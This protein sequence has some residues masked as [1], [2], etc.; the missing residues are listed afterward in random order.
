MR[1][2][3]EPPLNIP[4]IAIKEPEV[5]KPPTTYIISPT[6]GMGQTSRTITDKSSMKESSFVFERAPVKKKPKLKLPEKYEKLLDSII[7]DQVET[8]DFT[9]AELGDQVM[10]QIAE[11]IRGKKIKTLK[12]IR[13]KLTDEALDKMLPHFGGIITLNLSQ[14]LLTDRFIDH[15]LNHLPRLPLLKS[16]ILSQNKIKER[17]VK[18]RLEEIK[19]YEI[20][21]SL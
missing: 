8:A 12:L 17:S 6:N 5:L 20:V 2:V 10:V 19:K 4:S 21:V 14:N 9:N 1:E 11:Y 3:H 16:I 13:N 18:T 15:L 7:A